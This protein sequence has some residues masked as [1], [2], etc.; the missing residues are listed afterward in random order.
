MTQLIY[1][2]NIRV[3]TEKAH[4]LQIVQN[5]EAFANAG[6]HVCLWAARRVNTPAMRAVPDVYAHYGVQRNFDL[7]RLPTLDLLPL[8]PNRTDPLARVIFY[9]QLLTFT[10]SALVALLFSHA[11]VVYSRDPLVLLAASLVKPRHT[12][13]YEAH[14]LAVGRA[15]KAL[16]RT[17]VHRVGSVITITA[18]LREAL[19][20]QA[21]EQQRDKFRV[22]HDGVRAGRFA[23][24]P[25]REQAR[26]QIRWDAQAFI[27]GYV[28]RLHTLTQDKGL[29]TVIDAIAQ[30][31]GVSLALVGGPDDMAAE[32]RDH[33]IARGLPS[34]CFLYAGQVPP[35]A[36]PLHLAAF[37]VC[38][39]PHPFTP[40]FAYYTSPLKLFEY[41][42]SG[43]AIVA[44]DLP[45]WADV[46][47]D[48]ENALLVPPGDV[49]AM[50]RA[51]ARLQGDVALRGRLGAAAREDALAHYTWDARAGAILAHIRR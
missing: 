40:H 27:V 13:V 38:V 46:L 7:Q 42:A 24:M 28:G 45:G 2:A 31:E 48:G 5:C 1:I 39:M 33:W 17:V 4:G 43:R 49:G 3:P 25:S 6:A 47:R 26:T 41:M 29:R 20:E 8:V 37:D 9:L 14:Q 19:I 51:L 44:S 11:D 50:A 22:A 30:A 23:Q 18:P 32:H 34:A 15:G 35:D 10:L 21:G 16:Q 12:L 36:V